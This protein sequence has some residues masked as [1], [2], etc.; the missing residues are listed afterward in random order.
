MS[1]RKSPE[2]KINQTITEAEFLEKLK[3]MD[4]E[5]NRWALKML[6]YPVK[7]EELKKGF[8]GT[9]NQHSRMWVDVDMGTLIKDVAALNSERIV[10]FDKMIIYL[11]NMIIE[12]QQNLQRLQLFSDTKVASRHAEAE[13]ALRF[14]L[15]KKPNR[16]T[17]VV[18][19]S[20][21]QFEDLEIFI[22]IYLDAMKY[23]QA[24]FK[25]LRD[26]PE[27]EKDKIRAF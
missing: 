14:Y 22:N 13:R 25:V 20:I 2:G 16:Q 3:A 18:E 8:E 21:Q 12:I 26:L 10:F 24:I 17:N 5:E 1:K 9:Q 15:I 11:E 23:S 4:V 27:E 6:K 7:F 19:Y